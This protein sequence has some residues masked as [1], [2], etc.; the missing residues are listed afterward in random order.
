[1]W[2]IKKMKTEKPCSSAKSQKSVRQTLGVRN[3]LE[4]IYDPDAKVY[5]KGYRCKIHIYV[6][7]HSWHDGANYFRCTMQSHGILNLNTSFRSLEG[8]VEQNP[9]EFGTIFL[10]VY[11]RVVG[12][13]R[14]GSRNPPRAIV[15]PCEHVS[16]AFTRRLRWFFNNLPQTFL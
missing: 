11:H 14:P 12:M 8:P 1:M 5:A 6:H 3:P 10:P 16:S 2:P 15:L 7:V 13:L 4:S 9:V